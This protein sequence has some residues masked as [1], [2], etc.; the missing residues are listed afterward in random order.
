MSRRLTA[1]CTCCLPYHIARYSALAHSAPGDS[2]TVVEIARKQGRYPWEADVSSLPFELHSLFDAPYEDI[3]TADAVTKV[4]ARLDADQPDV[5]LVNGYSDPISRA[6]AAWGRRRRRTVITF[7]ECCAQD[8]RRQP[9]KELYKRYLVRKLFDG[10][11]AGGRRH[12]DY[13]RALGVPPDRVVNG[14]DVVDQPTVARA[15]A[16][17]RQDANARRSQLQLPERYFV[18]VG[19][20]APE[21]N[22]SGL[23]QAYGAYRRAAQHDPWDL[24]LVGAGP[25]EEAL[26]EHAADLQLPGV[27]WAGVRTWPDLASYYALASCFVLASRSEPWGLVVNEAATCGLPLLVSDICGCQ[28]EFVHNGVNGFTFSHRDIGQLAALMTRI[29]DGGLD[30]AAMGAASESI[31]AGFTPTTWAENLYQLIEHI[32]AAERR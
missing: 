26:K 31:A 10:A 13:A 18:Y 2:L 6:M 23:L 29:S 7:F 14:Y 24:V 15:A 25:L 27:Q 3:R 17:A 11:F 1:I 9:L 4:L 20:F 28:P 21:K 19:R 22:V 5:L 16:M 32:A 12:A 8:R 30:L